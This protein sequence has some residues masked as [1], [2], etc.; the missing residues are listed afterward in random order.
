M[1]V[2]RPGL[3]EASAAGPR[4]GSRQGMPDNINWAFNNLKP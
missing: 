3:H 2:L 1:M 4:E